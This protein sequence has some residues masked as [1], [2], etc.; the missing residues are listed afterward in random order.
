M[1]KINFGFCHIS[2]PHRWSTNYRRFLAGLLFCGVL[3]SAQAQT[4]G[5]NSVHDDIRRY[6]EDYVRNL[7]PV[8]SD[9]KLEVT[10][11][12]IDT[13]LPLT[14]CLG[15]LTADIRGA[16]EVQ[17]NTHVYLQCHEDPGWEIFV[18]VRVRVLKPVVTALDPIARNT[19]LQAQH[20]SVDY[21]DEVLLRGDIFSNPSDLVGSRSKRDLRPGQPIRSS[22]LCVVCKGDKVS[23]LAQTGGLMLKTDGIAEEDGAFND[24]IRVSNL[25]SGRKISARIVAAG[26]VQVK[27]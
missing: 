27:L 10:A 15:K 18:P 5:Y 11:A 19:L 20:L 8:Q 1:L 7:V 6:A 12:S 2:Q 23:I 14:E 4:S 13:R 16:G 3:G 9:D 21:Q 17:R 25:N 26:Q 22:Q 24:N